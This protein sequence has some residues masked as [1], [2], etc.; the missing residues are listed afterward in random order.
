MEDYLATIKTRVYNHEMDKI[1]TE[2]VNFIK[3]EETRKNKT[4]LIITIIWTI[5]SIVIL[6][7]SLG[8]NIAMP[9][10]IAYFAGAIFIVI[11]LYLFLF[12]NYKESIKVYDRMINY[13]N[14]KS[15]FNPYILSKDKFIN[16]LN[17]GGLM[18]LCF[19]LLEGKVF[20]VEAFYE[21]KNFVGYINGNKFLSVEDFMN[22]EL[23][24]G[25]KFNDLDNISIIEYNTNDPKVYFEEKTI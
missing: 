2:D 18:A 14:G 22:F 24:N 5:L 15:V 11:P 13:I 12:F 10:F 17:Y 1:T 6:V 19:V 3:K 9:S 16:E 7:L 23:I 4:L 20:Y 8:F 25:I 21:N